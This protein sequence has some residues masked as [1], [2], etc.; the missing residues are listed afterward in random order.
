[1]TSTFLCLLG[2]II[3]LITGFFYFAGLWVTVRRAVNST[4]P[5]RL[6]AL[7]TAARLLTVLFVMFLLMHK[8]LWMFSAMLIAFFSVRFFM[9]KRMR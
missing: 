2:V 8:D 9:I 5:K 1:M 7:S 3:G 4:R 6:M